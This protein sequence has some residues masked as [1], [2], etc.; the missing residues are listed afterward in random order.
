MNN[1]NTL[2][3]AW[4]LGSYDQIDCYQGGATLRKE[5]ICFDQCTHSGLHERENNIFDIDILSSRT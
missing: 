2:M 1:L 3:E 4:K 5:W